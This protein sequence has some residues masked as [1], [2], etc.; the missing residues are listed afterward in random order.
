MRRPGFKHATSI[1]SSGISLML[2]ALRYGSYMWG[3]RSFNKN[4]IKTVFSFQYFC[5]ALRG[6]GC[7]LHISI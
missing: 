6:R 4:T 2:Y 1:F 7:I 3:A 5:S